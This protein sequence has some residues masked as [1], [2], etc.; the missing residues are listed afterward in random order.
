MGCWDR[1]LSP[2]CLNQP[3]TGQQAAGGGGGGGAT[4]FLA[5]SAY[6]LLSSFPNF[7]MNI[8][9]FCFCFCLFFF[10][11][12]IGYLVSTEHWLGFI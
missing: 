2:G 11:K 7:S 8:H 12:L 9:T 1:L 4:L 3:I 6:F 5:A 10:Y